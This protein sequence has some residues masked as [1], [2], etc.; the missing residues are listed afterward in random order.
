[1]RHSIVDEGLARRLVEVDA[2]RVAAAAERNAPGE[3]PRFERR[4]FG[5]A[6]A[7]RDPDHAERGLLNRVVGLRP[8]DLERLDA[9]IA[10]YDEAGIAC[11]VD[12]PPDAVEHEVTEALGRAGFSP[13]GNHAVFHGIPERTSS[14]VPGVVV[15]H[16]HE[17]AAI[18]DALVVFDRL[19]SGPAPDPAN[20]AR[21]RAWYARYPGTTLFFASIDGEPV[22]RAAMLQVGESAHFSGDSTLPSHRGRGCQ[23]ALVEARIDA[24]ARAGCT[25]VVT[26]AMPGTSS[27]RNIVRAGFQ[28]TWTPAWWVRDARVR[29]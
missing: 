7:L 3:T 20:S 1:M 15:E 22:A 27:G 11:Q 25:L 6:I 26:D 2:A 10:F 21:R 16:V 24:A 28:L 17:P 29:E 14:S 12:V 5:Q 23:R 13:R 18:L 9:I 19:A 4:D 8:A